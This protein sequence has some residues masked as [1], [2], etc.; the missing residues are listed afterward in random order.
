MWTMLNSL[1]VNQ[2][3]MPVRRERSSGLRPRRREAMR[4]QIRSS[5]GSVGTVPLEPFS[6]WAQARSSQRRRRWPVSRER[7]GLLQSG[8]KGAVNG[9]NL[10][11]GLHLGTEP[12]VSGGE[13]IEGPAGYLDDAVVEGGF[14]GSSGLAGDGVGDFVQCLA[15]GGSWRRRVR[16]DSRWPCWPGRSCG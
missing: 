2:G 13:L 5:L 3:S 11:G 9:H 6:P 7:T 15:D 8:L 14:E 16:W 12:A 10:A 1:L 4:A